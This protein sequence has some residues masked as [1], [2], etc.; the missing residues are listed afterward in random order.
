[1]VTQIEVLST[2]IEL[3]AEDVD[4]ADAQIEVLVPEVLVVPKRR[5]PWPDWFD[6]MGS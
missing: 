5:T 2:G 6:A 1:M 4:L 3:P